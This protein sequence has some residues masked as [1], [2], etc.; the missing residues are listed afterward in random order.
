MVSQISSIRAKWWCEESRVYAKIVR[1]EM[2]GEHGDLLL[3]TNRHKRVSLELN[4]YNCSSN[5]TSVH[6]YK[7]KEDMENSYSDLLAIHQRK[8]TYGR[9]KIL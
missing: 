8:C 5:E 3:R 4:G 1:I 7:L 9:I 2:C 6:I